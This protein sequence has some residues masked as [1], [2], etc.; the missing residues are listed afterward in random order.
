METNLIYLFQI[1]IKWIDGVERQEVI[2]AG[3]MAVI[4]PVLLW[5]C[6]WQ[7]ARKRRHCG[8]WQK[9]GHTVLS[10]YIMEMS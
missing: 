5:K 7:A 2:H 6:I 1:A 8:F 3:V 10:I 4:Q 9:N